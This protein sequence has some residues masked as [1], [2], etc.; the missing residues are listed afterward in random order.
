MKLDEFAHKHHRHMES[1]LPNKGIL[2]EIDGDEAS[3]RFRS[4][5]KSQ[6][7][8]FFQHHNDAYYLEHAAALAQ[9]DCMDGIDFASSDFT[10]RM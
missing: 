10:G 9:D 3:S 7:Y 8:I 6:C 1:S 2:F 4:Q 5:N